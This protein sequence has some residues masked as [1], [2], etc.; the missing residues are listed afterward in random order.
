[1]E[2]M[3]YWIKRLMRQKEL[4]KQIREYLTWRRKRYPTTTDGQKEWLYRFAMYCGKRSIKFLEEQDV[5]DFVNGFNSDYQKKEAA[6]TVYSF[7]AFHGAG[8]LAIIQ[9]TSIEKVMAKT[10]RPADIFHIQKVKM[11]KNVERLSFRE[12]KERLEKEEKGRRFYVS[13]I[14][15]WYHYPLPA[16]GK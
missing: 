5:V 3:F 4:D 16:I 1:M 6:K 12:I 2:Y 15:S 8:D 13:Q 9:E 14:H 7:L 10:G 11:L